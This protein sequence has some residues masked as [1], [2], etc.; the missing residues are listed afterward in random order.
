MNKS[1]KLAL[2]FS[3]V[4]MPSISNAFSLTN[5]TGVT[6]RFW[7][8]PKTWSNPDTA[9]IF[10]G[11]I[12]PGQTINCDNQKYWCDS[13]YMRIYMEIKSIGDTERCW[14]SNREIMKLPPGGSIT[15]RN[16]ASS[17]N[18][19]IKITRKDGKVKYDGA[20]KQFYKGPKSNDRFKETNSC[21]GTY[22][23]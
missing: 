6:R 22:L 3:V 8:T 12:S 19:N 15:F 10:G 16:S 17:D 18:L 5:D 4:L 9:A 14:A 23:K 7:V 11:N 21:V 13:P 1:T 2:I 20:A